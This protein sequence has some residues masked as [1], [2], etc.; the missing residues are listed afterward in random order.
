MIIMMAIMV[1]PKM[2]VLGG[3][4]AAYKLIVRETVYSVFLEKGEC[5]KKAFTG[6]LNNLFRL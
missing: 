1:T 4:S 5:L 3:I 2:M 6:V